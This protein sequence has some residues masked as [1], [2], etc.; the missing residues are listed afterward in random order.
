M[1]D[2]VVNRACILDGTTLRIVDIGI[3]AGRDYGIAPGNPA[4]LVA[5]DARSPA[6]AVATIAQP[7]WGWRQGRRSFTRARAALHRP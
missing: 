6:D 4:D 3:E 5:I 1:F 7:L 2:L